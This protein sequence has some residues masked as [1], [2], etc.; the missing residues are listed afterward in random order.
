MASAY[1]ASIGEL[2]AHVLSEATRH[3]RLPGPPNS[4]FG[5]K[6]SENYMLSFERTLA[7]LI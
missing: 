5:I 3:S 1:F 7:V 4:L 2:M 6:A